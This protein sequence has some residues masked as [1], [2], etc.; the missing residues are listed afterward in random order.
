MKL[1][2]NNPYRTIGILVG[3]S[4]RE[5]ERQI[6]R[7]KQYLEAE[8]EPQDD[9]R[10]PTLGP[11]LRTLDTIAEAE[12]RL[13]L[14]KDRL[15][16]ALFWF[17]KGNQITDEPALDCLKEDKQAAS[18]IW[19][20][21]T[22][23]GEVTTRNS[24][25]FHNLSTLLLCSSYNG[26]SFDLGIFEKGISLKLKFLESDFV[27][28][29]KLLA[30]DETFKTTK[31]EIQLAFLDA[32]QIEL[33]KL[34]GITPNKLIEILNKEEFSAKEDFLK[35]FINKLIEQVEKKL[36]ASQKSRKND[37]VNAYSSGLKLY[38]DT[39]TDLAQI[40]KVVGSTNLKY[41]GIADKVSN[42]LLQCG[43]DYFTYYKDTS[44]DPSK[45]SMELF[46]KSKQLA[47]GNIAKQRCSENTENLQEWID[48][49]PERDKFEKIGTEL[50]K[51]KTIIDQFEKLSD[52]VANAKN[53][54]SA[55]LPGL[56]KVKSVLGVNDDLYLGFSTRIASDA[57]GMCVTEINSIQERIGH[58]SDAITNR[59][60]LKLLELR[61]NEARAVLVTIETM[62]LMQEFINRLKPN[63]QALADMQSQFLSNSLRNLTLFAYNQPQIPSRSSSSGCY[64]ATMAY[65][66]Y[67]HPQVLILRQFRDNILSNYWLG[68]SFIRF[69]Y[70]ISPKLVIL[71]K[72]KKTYNA[73][74]RKTLNQIIKLM[75]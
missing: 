15:S 57:L 12:S 66:D 4:A 40:S 42:E 71:L 47:V 44:K 75:K 46:V 31:K 63:K 2:L 73:L 74:I 18:E 53:Q 30:T 70:Y 69:Y 26:S 58:A 34:G 59:A 72:D 67:D 64:I 65:G 10:F 29:F 28:D 23:S 16:A 56:Q 52:T 32:L 35:S 43:I 21:L 6:K 1:V 60:S 3:A 27:K 41:S 17:Y 11:L 68:R 20:K 50:D 9:F 49:K 45:A 61:V 62:D 5:K 13:N 54:L 51:L 24:S 7:L 14:D 25:A 37:A 33:E 55:S 8:Q 48:E 38:N 19:L 36:A 22:A 39:A